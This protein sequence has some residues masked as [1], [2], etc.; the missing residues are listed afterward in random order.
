MHRRDGHIHQSYLDRYLD[1]D[2]IPCV[3][4]HHSFLVVSHGLGRYNYLR[5]V[6]GPEANEQRRPKQSSVPLR[7]GTGVFWSVGATR[8]LDDIVQRI[9]DAVAHWH[10]VGF[11]KSKQLRT[12]VFF[13][14][15]RRIFGIE[16][17]P[18]H[19]PAGAA[20]ARKGKRVVQFSFRG[21]YIATVCEGKLFRY[22]AWRALRLPE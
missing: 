11:T 5:A 1:R 15:R 16:Q 21:R 2:R 12:V 13:Y 9:V 20:L 17:N 7:H 18:R 10:P 14:Q 19:N 6:S 22:P 3:R 8:P 4:I